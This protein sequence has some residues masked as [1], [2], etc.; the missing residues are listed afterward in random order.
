MLA[1]RADK[2][3]GVASAVSTVCILITVRTGF[4]LRQFTVAS[5]RSA[6]LLRP[7]AVEVA[8]LAAKHDHW[9]PWPTEC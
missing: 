9:W 4:A 1:L 7:G 2:T 6:Y 8:L 3:A 5:G